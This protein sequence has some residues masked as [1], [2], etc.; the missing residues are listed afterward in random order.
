MRKKKIVRNSDFYPIEKVNER[1]KFY[2][3]KIETIEDPEKVSINLKL[4][5]FWKNYKS[6]NYQNE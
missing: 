3:E 4:L 1:I 5:T 6:N 2:K